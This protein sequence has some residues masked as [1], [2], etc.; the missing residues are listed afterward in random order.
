VLVGSQVVVTVDA[1][2]QKRSVEY[3]AL[4]RQ[5]PF[6][7]SASDRHGE[8]KPPP[9]AQTPARGA[10]SCRH[11]QVPPEG[12]SLSAPHSGVHWRASQCWATPC[13]EGGQSSSVT[14]A[15]APF[16]AG[17]QRLCQLVHTASKGQLASLAQP[18]VQ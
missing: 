1:T 4:L 12:Q 16:A 3:G 11:W 13:A 9:P 14:Q 15:A 5:K 2:L 8:Q 10:Q 17:V 7:Q 18:E 6:V